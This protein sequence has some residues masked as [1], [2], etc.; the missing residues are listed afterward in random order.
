MFRRFDGGFRIQE[1]LD[2]WRVKFQLS[3]GDAAELGHAPVSHQHA[4]ENMPE[5][6]V[7]F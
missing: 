4:E 5:V 6:W 7:V 3:S 2:A 1:I